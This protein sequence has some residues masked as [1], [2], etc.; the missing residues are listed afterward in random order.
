MMQVTFV[1]FAY[2]TDLAAGPSYLGFCLRS[3]SPRSISLRRARRIHPPAAEGGLSKKG[4]IDAVAGILISTD[5]V[6]QQWVAIEWRKALMS[7]FGAKLT[8]DAH[9]S[10]IAG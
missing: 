4:R 10:N 5:E 7:A 2:I 6:R 3:A 1:G 9:R 8:C